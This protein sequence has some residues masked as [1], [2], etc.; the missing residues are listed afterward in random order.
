[1]RAARLVGVGLMVL[2]V[3]CG[4]LPYSISTSPDPDYLQRCKVGHDVYL[5]IYLKSNATY[6]VSVY[7][8]GK[9]IKIKP[10]IGSSLSRQNTCDAVTIGVSSTVVFRPLTP[11]ILTV[12]MAPLVNRDTGLEL[13]T[14]V[15]RM[16]EVIP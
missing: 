6:L 15:S 12:V 9:P 1:M 2:M 10:L 16:I 4:S 7:M 14:A 8:Q 3:G 5:T 11:G 13:G